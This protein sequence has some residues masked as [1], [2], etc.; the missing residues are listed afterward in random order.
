MSHVNSTIILNHI[1]KTDQLLA[2]KR[3]DIRKFFYNILKFV[4][5][6][7]RQNFF[8]IAETQ[9]SSVYKI[10]FIVQNTLHSTR[11]CS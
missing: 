2:Y 1:Y 6:L 3:C 4:S 10:L 11:Y 5:I 8:L 7:R 9:E